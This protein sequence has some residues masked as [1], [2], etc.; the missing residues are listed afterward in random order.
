MT[1]VSAAATLD[2]VLTSYTGYRALQL[3][4][5]N[6]RPATDAQALYLRFSTDGG[7]TF[8]AGVSDY[9]WAYVR[10]GDAALGGNEDV[11]DSEIQ[12]GPI[13][14]NAATEGGSFT[15]TIY[16]QTSTAHWTKCFFDGHL[17]DINSNPH[18]LIGGGAR[19]AT[20]DTDAIRFLMSSG[21][22]AEGNWAL[23]GY[24]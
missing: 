15:L 24:A 5:G 23:Y 11:A 1:T 19:E 10:F 12:I 4:L 18:C 3:V 7:S 21:N 9:N 13:M 22:I 2:I 16:Q 6:F 20:Q 14:G 17:I 8:D